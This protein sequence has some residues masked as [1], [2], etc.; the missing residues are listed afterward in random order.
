M[1]ILR[2]YLIKATYNWLLDHKLKPYILV[3]TEHQ[4][5]KVPKNY[6]D[7]DGKI[8]LNLSDKAVV[9]FYFDNKKIEFDATF[10]GIVVSVIIPIEAI[11]ELYSNETHQGLYIDEI[12]YDI[13]INEGKNI[14]DFDPDRNFSLNNSSKLRII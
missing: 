4:G 13:S 6:I 14:N 12:S 2:T 5:V 10:D 1:T 3:N 9:N 7:N 8:L 11:L